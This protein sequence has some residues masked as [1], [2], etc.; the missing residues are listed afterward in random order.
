MPTR[1]RYTV[2]YAAGL[3]VFGPDHHFTKLVEGRLTDGTASGSDGD[4]V[5]DLSD[6]ERSEL[7]ERYDQIMR[8]LPVDPIAA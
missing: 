4:P 7:L 5:G 2:M 8:S 6:A 1:L 3:Q